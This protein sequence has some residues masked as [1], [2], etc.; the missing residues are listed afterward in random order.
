V[1]ASRSP[2]G[3]TSR[4]RA[5]LGRHRFD[6]HHVDIDPG[7]I[8]LDLTAAHW[9]RLFRSTGFEVEDH[10]ELQAPPGDVCPRPR[11]GQRNGHL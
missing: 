2:T 4:R 3:A 6:W 9:L 1:R 5:V 10:L 8:E 7:G 11:S